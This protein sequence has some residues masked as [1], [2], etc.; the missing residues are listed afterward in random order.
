[1]SGMLDGL[2]LQQDTG[3]TATTCL[4][5]KPNS[6]R[7]IELAIQVVAGAVHVSHLAASLSYRML[8]GGMTAPVLPGNGH[9]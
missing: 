5:T 9:F 1:M 4:A 8:E 7:R 3:M 6:A 2:Q